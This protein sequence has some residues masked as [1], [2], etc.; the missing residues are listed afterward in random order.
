MDNS[1]F[2]RI[3]DFKNKLIPDKQL[4][5]LKNGFAKYNFIVYHIKGNQNLIPDFLTRPTI[6]KPLLISSIQTIPVIAINHQLP[7]KALNQRNFPMNI[8]FQS[9]Y[10]L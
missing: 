2:P 6:N 9:A 10:Q 1:Y 5:S 8:S 4:L 3:F 7:F